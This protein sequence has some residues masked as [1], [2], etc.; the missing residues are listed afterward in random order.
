[1]QSSRTVQIIRDV[2]L[3]QIK[4]EKTD[5]TNIKDCL[6]SRSFSE[7]VTA[8]AA[9]AADSRIKEVAWMYPFSPTVGV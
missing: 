3:D 8:Q 9:T 6:M 2:F 5:S 4:C 7:I 1:M